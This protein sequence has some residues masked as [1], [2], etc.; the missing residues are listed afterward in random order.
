MSSQKPSLH[1]GARPS[2]ETLEDRCQPALFGLPWADAG[3]LTVSFAPDGTPLPSGTSNLG[4]ALGGQMAA[5]AW[6]REALRAL[7]TWAV[8]ANLNVGVVADGGQPLGAAGAVQGDGRFGDVRLAGKPMSGDVLAVSVP[9]D[10]FL[11]GTWAGDVVVNTSA[12]FDPASFYRVMVHEAAHVFGLGNSA[13]PRSVRFSQFALGTT[14]TAQDIADLQALYGARRPDA[15]EVKKPNDT[16]KNATRLRYSADSD[17]FTGQT[18]VVA[19]GDLTTTRDTDWFYLPTLAGY[20]GPVTFRVQSAGLSLLA[21]L[22]SVYDSAGRLLGSAAAADPRGN[23][24]SV[25]LDRVA[26]DA[27]YYVRVTSATPDVFG[28]GRYA[29]VATFDQRLTMPAAE[30]NRLIQQAPSGLGPDDVDEL[31]REGHEALYRP[32]AGADDDLLLAGNLEARVGPGGTAAYQVVG[33]IAPAGD[34]DYYRLRPAR[35]ASRQPQVMAVTLVRSAVN[36]ALPTVE[37]LDGAGRVLATEV[38]VRTAD[39]LT[40]QASGLAANTSYFLRVSGTAA[41][42]GNYELTAQ[43]GVAAAAQATFARGAVTDAQAEQTYRV[44]IGQSQLFQ[45]SL[46][47]LAGSL[48]AAGQV[49]VEMRDARG[50]VVLSLAAGVGETNTAPAVFLAPGAYTV[51]VRRVGRGSLAYVLRGASL[52]DPIGPALTDPTLAPQYRVPNDPTAFLYPGNVLLLDPFFWVLLDPSGPLLVPGPNGA[53]VSAFPV[54]GG[55]PRG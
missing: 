34:V 8:N 30:I 32:D 40:V 29:V 16:Q 48:G 24:I 2:L 9:H 25:R 4:A 36:G 55:A 47:A 3:H 38:V 11:A 44:F 46:S 28:I 52:S 23:T 19:F 37:L 7:Q 20:S 26:P 1:Q 22:M 18:P 15:N 39:R 49:V 35:T 13:D 33:S 21:P 27:K 42:A 53:P 14:I 41:Q 12:R 5:S 54:F 6:Q 31:F 17:G 10:P 51:T 43:A 50:N 45:F